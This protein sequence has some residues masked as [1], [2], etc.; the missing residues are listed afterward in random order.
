MPV[1]DAV[2]RIPPYRLSADQAE[3]KLNQNESA[4][5]LPE[6]L[7]RD[8][9]RRLSKIPFHRYPDL[10]ADDLRERI[11][12]YHDW[13]AEGVV[14]T[15]GSNVLIQCIV[16]AC[17]L[18]RSVLTV[19][20]TFAV[21]RLEAQLLGAE[22][23]EVP[24]APDFGL[25]TAALLERMAGRGGVLFVTDPAAPTGNRLDPQGVR[26]LAGAAGEAWTVVID[27]AYAHFSGSDHLDLIRAGND[28]VSLRTFSKA[29]G[30][31][32]VRLGYALTSPELAAELRK[33]ALPFSVSA[34]QMAIG[35]VVLEHPELIE[36]RVAEA[37]AERERISAALGGMLDLSVFPSAANFLLIRCRD[38]ER[39]F[40]AL[41]ERGVLVRRQDHLPGL[42]GCLRISVGTPDE[43]DRLLDALSDALGRER[44][45]EHVRSS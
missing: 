15:G 38:P 35:A 21:Y 3:V 42:D 8:A 14:V 41:L 32:G 16:I 4:Y 29:L 24:L 44:V 1:R 2:R 13:P 10:Q 20:P 18:G 12:R 27:E 5:D 36:E 28:I 9:L 45:G 6:P 7:K 17:G 33:V 26:A 19:E 31:G 23:I 43:N 34:L 39:L 25:P 22:L 37:V 30:L 11:G 40:A